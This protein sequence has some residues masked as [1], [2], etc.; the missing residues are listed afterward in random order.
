MEEKD[1]APPVGTNDG[2]HTNDPPRERSLITDGTCVSCSKDATGEFMECNCCLIRYHVVNCK[3][4]NLCTVT[5]RND[6]FARNSRLYPCIGFTCIFCRESKKL[7]NDSI[8][9][10]RLGHMENNFK[11]LNETLLIFKNI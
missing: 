6:Y 10:E 2:R 4:D 11:T 7:S 8:L 9:A 5:F 3:E 1:A